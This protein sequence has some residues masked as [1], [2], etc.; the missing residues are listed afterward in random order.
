[1]LLARS[2]F[3]RY[4]LG[5]GVAIALLAGCGESQPPIGASGALPQSRTIAAPAELTGSWML[6][7]AKDE[8]LLY[9]A[10]ANANTV[11]VY[12]YSGLK[13]VG[14]LD[15]DSPGGECVDKSGDV[16][17]TAGRQVFEYRHAGS[18]AIETFGAENAWACSVNFESGALAV[19]NFGNDY[20]AGFVEVFR[21]NKKTVYQDKALYYIVACGYDD[22]GNLLIGGYQSKYTYKPVGFAMLTEGGNRLV[23][24]SL[25]G[26]SSWR[27]IAAVQWDGRHWAVTIASPHRAEMV[28]RFDIANGH[29]KAIGKIFLANDPGKPGQAW[30]TEPNDGGVGKGAQIVAGLGPVP[31]V[32]LWN[33]PTGQEP[34]AWLSDGGYPLGVTV[35]PA[36]H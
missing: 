24:I 18:Q 34:F 6:P 3:N 17:V 10:N 4:A 12:A 28:F 31:K 13:L 23:P 33:Y 27:D 15:V 9:V 2:R 19:S 5:A 21:N 22:L 8:N 14:T 16:Y 30:I 29:A 36:G 20:S 26:E 1:V 35:S 7:E 32:R 25:P 11:T